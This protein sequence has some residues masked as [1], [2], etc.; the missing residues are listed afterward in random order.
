MSAAVLALVLAAAVLHATWNGM[1]KAGRDR[2]RGVAVMSMAG[3]AIGLVAALVLPAPHSASWPAI[4]LSGLLHV[5]YNLF[6]VRAY[7]HGDLSE[8]YPIARGSAP[9]LVTAGGVLLAG[10]RI[11]LPELGGVLMVSAGILSLARG[12]GNAQA[13]GNLLSALGT[14]LF[15]AAYTVSDGIGG[16][17]SGNPLAYAAWLFALGG[18]PMALAFWWRRG[19][20]ARLFEPG[21]ETL[22]GLA[23]GIVSMMAYGLVIWAASVAPMGAVSA[24][25]ETSVVFA[26]L[27]GRVA[28]G[29]TFRPRR[30]AGCLAVVAGALLLAVG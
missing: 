20:G 17:L 12:W 6:L 18:P 4:A 29:E 24:L 11:T 14:G 16:R 19:F 30:V 3:S 13:R 8:V 7:R 25:R 1:L 9:L 23:G 5:G 26:L 15:I 10:D 22:K 2:L 21:A 28:F 27:I